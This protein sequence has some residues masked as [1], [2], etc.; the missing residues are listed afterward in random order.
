M[1][2]RKYN[3]FGFGNWPLANVGRWPL[4]S[5]RRFSAAML[6]VSCVL[7][8]VEAIGAAPEKPKAVTSRAA[9]DEAARSI[10]FDLLTPEA[11]AKAAK[12]IK[13]TSLFRRLPV[14]K[15]DC[16]PE[17]YQF[18]VHNPDVVVNIWEVMGI[19]QMSLERAEGNRYKVVD[20]EGTKGHLEYLFKSPELTIIYSEG[21]YDGRL[22]PRT[23]R[24]ACVMV[25]RSSYQ[26][27]PTGRCI[28]TS[29][30]DTFLSV[31]N[32]GVEILAKT[33][34]P[35]I[36]NAADHNFAES[37]IFISKLS[38]TAETN[39]D[40]V[41]RLTKKLDRIS[42]ETKAGF[43]RVVSHVAANVAFNEPD[44]P[45]SDTRLV[46]GPTEVPQRSPQR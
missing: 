13:N 41:I 20:G 29:R 3:F 21:T 5:A 42:P 25:L 6:A 1:A 34:Q 28:I 45:D 27:E 18:A 8:A 7:S 33:F 9:R 2:R 30:L 24:G 4:N 38:R 14:E 37:G 19:S 16:A 10:P 44:E 12:V 35:I 36:G 17:M 39:E 23:V 32:L 31:E 40:G 46:R 22:Y 11:Q 43:S 26:R 15:F